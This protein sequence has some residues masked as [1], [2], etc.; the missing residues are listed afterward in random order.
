MRD[1]RPQYLELG[2]KQ[3]EDRLLRLLLSGGFGAGALVGLFIISGRLVGA[4]KGWLPIY[5]KLVLV[6]PVGTA[7]AVNQD[8]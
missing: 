2:P 3:L 7:S 6:F 5:P 1:L 8:P 4:L